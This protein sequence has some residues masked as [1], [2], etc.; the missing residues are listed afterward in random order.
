MMM[1]MVMVI[2]AA[3]LCFS[4]SAD[5]HHTHRGKQGT[6]RKSG[7]RRHHKLSNK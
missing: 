5:K 1:V 3:W 4:D 7:Q 2:M 6:A